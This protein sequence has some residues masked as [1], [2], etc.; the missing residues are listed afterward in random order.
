[1]LE[2]E[3]A[4][5]FPPEGIDPAIAIYRRHYPGLSERLT[6]ALPGAREAIA[7]VRGA[8]ARAV[9]ISAKLEATARLSL[10]DVALDVDAVYGGVHGPEKAVVL[11][12]LAAAAY[13][14]DTP[15]DMAAAVQ[16]GAWAVG[17]ATGS[18]TEGDLRAAGAEVVLGSLAEFPGWLAGFP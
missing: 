14:G 18:F 15:A 12:E 5:W 6:S 7:A 16:A 3:L 4:H 13:V 2:V 17:V 8:G 1:K 11:A 9:V 10:D